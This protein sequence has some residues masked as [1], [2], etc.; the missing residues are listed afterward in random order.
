MLLGQSPVRGCDR[1]GLVMATERRELE[2]LLLYLPEPTIMTGCP[3]ANSMAPTTYS[4]GGQG[5][6]KIVGLWGQAIIPYESRL[7]H[8][9]GADAGDSS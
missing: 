1:S 8:G 2:L 6:L 5:A 3:P 7:K 4:R 9:S